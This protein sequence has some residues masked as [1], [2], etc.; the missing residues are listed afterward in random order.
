MV[1]PDQALIYRLSGDR[2]PLHVDPQVAGAAGFDKPI[3]HGLCTYGIACRAILKTI[4]DYDFTLI[5]G[6]DARFSAPVMPGDLLTTEMWQERNVVSFRCTVKA[7]DVI[8]IKNGK[9]TL[10]G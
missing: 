1:R 5:T 7:R 4:C 10:S 2:N 6:F 3:L 8:V 9:C